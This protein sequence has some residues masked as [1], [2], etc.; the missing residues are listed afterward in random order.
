MNINPN[1]LF[2]IKQIKTYTIGKIE[3]PKNNSIIKSDPKN[4]DRFYEKKS[5]ILPY[6][7]KQRLI[8]INFLDVNSEKIEVDRI[9]E[10][11]YNK[12]GQVN[13]TVLKLRSIAQQYNIGSG[14]LKRE[15]V[16]DIREYFGLENT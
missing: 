7:V 13:Y 10:G 4:I 16:R 3:L 12:Y 14:T 15:L 8:G 6:T 11:R 9:N 2:N 1:A 5:L